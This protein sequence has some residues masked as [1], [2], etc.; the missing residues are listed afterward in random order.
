MLVPASLLLALN[1]VR[2]GSVF[3]N[4]ATTISGASLFPP[5]CM[6]LT[7][8]HTTKA[9]QHKSCPAI[10]SEL[11][12]FPPLPVQKF[13]AQHS[14]PSSSQAPCQPDPARESS[15]LSSMRHSTWREC[16]RPMFWSSLSWLGSAA[17]QRRLN[18]FLQLLDPFLHP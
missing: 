17:L 12:E 15:T 9:N 14:A 5:Y 4:C 18:R 3:S 13:L 10:P 2:L 16:K 11:Y 1:I 6:R 8:A 7:P